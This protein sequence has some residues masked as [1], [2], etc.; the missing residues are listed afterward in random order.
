MNAGLVHP[1][2]AVP[3]LSGPLPVGDH[4]IACLGHAAPPES[5]GAGLGPATG[6]DPAA[7]PAAVLD[8]LERISVQEMS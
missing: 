6:P 2:P 7:V 1:R 8:L 3:A 4:T 5:E